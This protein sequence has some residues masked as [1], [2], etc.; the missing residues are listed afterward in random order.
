MSSD[1]I[2]E[3]R[4]STILIASTF[5]DPGGGGSG[6]GVFSIDGSHVER[7]DRISTVGM[8]YDGRR[9]ARVVRGPAQGT[10]GSEIFIYDSL[11]VQRYLRIDDVSAVHDVAWDGEN[12]A[13][14][15]TWD[16]AVRWFGPTGERLREVQF[17]GPADK[18][19]LNC[20]TQ[21]EGDWYATMFGPIGPFAGAV[22]KRDEAG[23]IVRL[24]TGE[25][26]AE[27]LTAPHTPRWLDGVWLVCNSATG[28]L[29]AI[30][31]DSGRVLR[32]VRCGDWTRGIAWDDDF[33]YVGTSKRRASNRSYDH[34]E[35]V[36]L[37]RTSW[38]PLEHVVVDAQ[39]IYELLVVARPV[40][41]GLRHG[42]DVNPQRTGEY[43]QYQIMSELG[44]EQPR[45]L[46]PCGEALPW[47]DFR[48]AL[49]CTAPAEWSADALVE[50]PVR[51]TNRSRSFFTSTPPAPVFVSYKW[52]DPANGTYLTE[53]RA[54]RSPLPRT[55]FPGETVE[56]N[57]RI[58]VP[59]V[60]GPATLRITPIQEGIA[61]FDDQD[62]AN[63]LEFS[64]EIGPAVPVI[65]EPIVR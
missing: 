63:G 47:D 24:M 64:V 8:S 27:G 51:L 55:I 36:V 6:G 46:W 33:L 62:P 20:I 40:E 18:W 34:A 58:V 60:E 41:A 12:L 10:R 25:T 7:I 17:A 14:V 5:G 52:F 3:D 1:A 53:A 37:D 13:V 49:E 30:D 31:P 15:S 29:F 39:E 22:P 19:H 56:V 65:W 54:F 45:T 23:R 11:G 59:S 2:P 61:W 32:R 44:V 9:L 43:R 57:V 48:S 28:E 16:N 4:T 42:F 50:L 35:V 26:V 38:T 21:H